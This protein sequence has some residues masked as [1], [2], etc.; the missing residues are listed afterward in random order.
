MVLIPIPYFFSTLDLIPFLTLN[1]HQK[2]P[3]SGNMSINQGSLKRLLNRKNWNRAGRM[4][5]LVLDSLE[6]TGN[7]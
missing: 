4:C 1:V 7:G 2:F 3:S 6:G 5:S